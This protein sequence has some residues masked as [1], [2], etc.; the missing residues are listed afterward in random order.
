MQVYVDSEGTPVQELSAI[1]VNSSTKEIEDV[2]HAFARFPHEDY[3]PDM[4]A[5]KHVHGL[6]IDFLSRN[7]VD[8]EEELVK[9]FHQWLSAH[10]YDNIF[11]HA[12]QKEEKLLGI[13][14]EDVKLLPWVE[15][16]EELSHILAK[17]LKE[18]HSFI[19]N[20]RC[21]SAHASF[22]ASKLEHDDCK[23]DRVKRD[24]GYHCS[25]YDCAECFLF[26]E[27]KE[28]TITSSL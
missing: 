5:R 13:C 21:A 26:K 20:V 24:F 18:T 1:Y 7:G 9:D 23:K 25:L 28:K 2:F 12:P 6:D 8:N 27:D 3:D 4:W 22:Q 19:C 14:I 17:R 10:P 15:R 11:G 16:S